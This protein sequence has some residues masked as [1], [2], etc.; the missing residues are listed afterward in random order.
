MTT[1]TASEARANLYRLTEQAAESHE[2][3]FI[4]VFLEKIHN[5]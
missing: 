3:I 2:P 1:L 5:L 4:T